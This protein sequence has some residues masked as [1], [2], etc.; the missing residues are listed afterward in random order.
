MAN[1]KLQ[2][3]KPRRLL[4][5]PLRLLLPLQ[6]LT[7]PLL[8]LLLPQLLL[9]LPPPLLLLLP[10]LRQRPP[11]PPPPL[12]LRLLPLLPLQLLLLLLLQSQ[13]KRR[14]SKS[15]A[16][17][18]KRQSNDWRF[19]SPCGLTK[20]ALR[21]VI[22]PATCSEKIRGGANQIRHPVRQFRP[23]QARIPT[24]RRTQTAPIHAYCSAAI[25]ALQ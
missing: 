21:A 15:S 3:L 20:P 11:P 14:R 8:L 25:D 22:V 6:R 18:K 17:Q 5:L 2:K 4:H 9:L 1:K 13:P 10:L 24:L 23:R 7:L 12:L 19:F 16:R